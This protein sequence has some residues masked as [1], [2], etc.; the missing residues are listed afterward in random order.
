MKRL[1]ELEKQLREYKE[2][3][4]KACGSK[5][6]EK[7]EDSKAIPKAPVKNQSEH[8]PVKVTDV[9]AGTTKVIE[10]VGTTKFKKEEDSEI[11]KTDANGQWS[12]TKAEKAPY[13]E[14]SGDKKKPE[15][16][17]VPDLKKE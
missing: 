17:K 13:V 6:I 3:L 8:G 10:S 4:E 2:E 15:D 1:L 9:K 12:I 14:N 16:S 7:A 11:C 5:D